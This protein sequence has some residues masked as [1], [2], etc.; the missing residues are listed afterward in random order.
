MPENQNEG[1]VG[2]AE[3]IIDIGER[4]GVWR[5]PSGA[6]DNGGTLSYDEQREF[7][8]ARGFGFLY[9][10]GGIIDQYV[11]RREGMGGVAPNGNGNGVMTTTD[12]AMTGGILV[13][14]VLVTGFAAVVI[15][16]ALWFAKSRMR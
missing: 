4:I 5:R 13:G 12:M 1:W 10:P 2:Q 9:E 6:S 3:D 16:A 11:A 8:E 7:L 15:L 14:G